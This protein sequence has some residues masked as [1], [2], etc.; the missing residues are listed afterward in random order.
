MRTRVHALLVPLALAIVW[1]ACLHWN[2]V[3]RHESRST[4]HG[5]MLDALP[6]YNPDRVVFYDHLVSL[7][8]S[9][10]PGGCAGAFHV[11]LA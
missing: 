5:V 4:R 8:P 2:D 9:C 7:G 10:L 1:W 3:E 6:V 11:C